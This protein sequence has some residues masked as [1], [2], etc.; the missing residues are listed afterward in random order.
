M[1]E[2]EFSDEY[3][4][5]AHAIAA[6]EAQRAAL[7]DAVVDPMIAAAREKL[8]ALEAARPPSAELRGERRRATI[9]MADVKGSTELAG[10]IGTETWVE[11]M[12]RVFHLLGDAIYRYG[13][14]IDQYRGDGLVAFF[15]AKAAHED[16]PERAVR[17]ALAMQ[18]AVKRYATELEAERGVELLLRIGINT[19][20]VI[21]AEVGDRRQHSEDTAKG[22]AIAIAARMESA[23][24]PGTVLVTEDTC[25][26]TRTLFE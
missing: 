23:A 17:A 13:G 7:G 4:Q 14:E 18:E 2:P 10:K 26:L 16:D 21:A 22:R 12:N 25:R 24:Q 15:G 3:R 9:L 20:E 19:G 11:I 8:A 6:L 5:L 1:S